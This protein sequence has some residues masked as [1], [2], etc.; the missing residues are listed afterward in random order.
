MGTK[1]LVLWQL[2]FPYSRTILAS[3]YGIIS[4]YLD[5]TGS[6]LCCYDVEE[7]IDNSGKFV[8]LDGNVLMSVVLKLLELLICYFNTR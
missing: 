5:Y 2:L 8:D 4:S 7:R 3:N 6:F 1:Y